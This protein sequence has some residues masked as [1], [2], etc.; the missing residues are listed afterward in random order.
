[1]KASEC[2]DPT[3]G[4]C[5][6]A[7]APPGGRSLDREQL[8][9]LN[10]CPSCQIY[11][12]RTR[13]LSRVWETMEPTEVELAA[14]RSKFVTARRGRLGRATAAPG[15][16]VVAM[17]LAAA[18]ASAAARI[19]VIR[20][21]ARARGPATFERSQSPPSR[22]NPVATKIT[23]ARA[24]SPTAPAVSV[25]RIAPVLSA[26]G[27]RAIDAPGSRTG[28]DALETPAGRTSAHG[29]DVPA[30]RASGAARPPS[31]VI[32]ALSTAAEDQAGSRREWLEA[33]SAM[34]VGDLERA[35]VAFGELARSRDAHTRDAARLSRAQLWIVRGRGD[36]ARRELDDL[37]R[38][39]ATTQLREA[40][41][42]AL[43]GLRGNS[44]RDPSSGTNQP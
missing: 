40:A 26:E 21:A 31:F 18:A 35:D 28:R 41:A 38:A 39:G 29:P 22:S 2:I 20:F 4:D 3:V 37:A 7:C 42:A 27:E 5:V 8:Q 33:A 15:A 16:I 30:D 43:D 11:V 36:D 1:M 10:A 14:A 6:L 34:R 12:E 23:V 19:G 24:E 32:A 9:H 44:S 25:E 13:R 17:L